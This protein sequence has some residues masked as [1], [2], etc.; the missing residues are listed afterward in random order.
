MT[1]RELAEISEA[2]DA[3]DEAV[4]GNGDLIDSAGYL[5]GLVRDYVL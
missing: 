5:V 3:V 2:A 4:K 1:P